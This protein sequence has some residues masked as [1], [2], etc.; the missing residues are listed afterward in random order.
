MSAYNIDGEIIA[1]M[2]P[3]E[4]PTD[5]LSLN[6][7]VRDELLQAKRPMNLSV[8][9]YLSNTQPLVLLWFSDI[10][11]DTTELERTIQLRDEYVSMLDDT[12]CTGDMVQLRASDGM[13]FWYDTEG[14][15]DILMVVG[16]HDALAAS[17]GY[18]WTNLLTEQE[19]Y[20]RYIAPNV[21]KWGV[22][23]TSGKTYY[24][25]DY[26][27]KKVRIIALNCMLT[28]NDDTAQQA[29]LESTLASARTSGLSVVIMAHYH[30][31]ANKSRLSCNFSPIDNGEGSAFVTDA[32][33][34]LVQTFINDGGEFICYLAGHVHH[35]CILK[36]NANTNQLCVEI[37]ALSRYYGNQYSDLQR[38]DGVKAQ[39][40]INLIVFDTNSKAIKIIRVGA[41]MDHYIRQRNGITIKYLTGD[42]ISQF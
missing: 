10:H 38:T 29:W 40:L 20:N 24:Y 12:I 31:F 9:E 13:S 22:Q 36:S 5:I 14:T 32:Y 19:Q 7:D 37:D 21:A 33:E 2:N 30:L 25:K 23:Y 42:V 6:P 26:T 16:N 15:E 8:N 1:E 39:D 17:T 41:N 3:T 34:N 11:A 27:A 4:K 35:D 28:G 18:D